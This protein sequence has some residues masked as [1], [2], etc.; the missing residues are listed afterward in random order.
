MKRDNVP[1]S[2]QFPKVLTLKGLQFKPVAPNHCLKNA[3]SIC[4]RS[5]LEI[6]WGA[7]RLI[8]LLLTIASSIYVTPSRDDTEVLGMSSYAI[9]SSFQQNKQQVCVYQKKGQLMMLENITQYGHLM[10]TS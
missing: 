6:H 4:V 9:P 7:E 1:R 2:G 5:R 3:D 10:T 8:K